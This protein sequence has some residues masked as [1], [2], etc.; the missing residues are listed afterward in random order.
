MPKVKLNQ[1]RTKRQKYPELIE[2]LQSCLVSE[3]TMGQPLIYEYEFR[4]G[5]LR[6]LVVWDKWKMLSLE[7]RTGIILAAYQEEHQ[8]IALASGLTMLEAVTAGFLSFRIIPALRSRDPITLQDCWKA[9]K[10]VGASEL[11]GDEP[12]LYFA[13]RQEAEK[14]VATLKMSLPKSREV[15]QIIQE[16]A[17]LAQNDGLPGELE[18]PSIPLPPTQPI[19]RPITH[20]HIHITPHPKI[21]PQH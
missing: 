15:W 16:S 5:L 13:T 2:E 19:P 14:G 4:N 18:E 20:Q 9:M 3:N 21:L 17:G 7:S 11:F 6:V 1:Q 12:R 8:D 10:A